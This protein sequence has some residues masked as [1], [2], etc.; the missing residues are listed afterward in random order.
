MPPITTD[1][2]PALPYEVTG[3]NGITDTESVVVV[4][5]YTTFDLSGWT[6]ADWISG[7]TDFDVVDIDGSGLAEA[8]NITG[9]IQNDIIKGGSLADVINGDD[10]NDTI[11]GGAG[12]DDIDGGAGIDYI[13]WG[14]SSNDLI[15]VLSDTPGAGYIEDTLTGETDTVDNVE[16]VDTGSGADQFTVSDS[17]DNIINAGAGIDTAKV[18]GGSGT[19]TITRDGD[20][21]DVSDTGGG[22]GTDQYNSVAQIDV[23][24]SGTDD[25]FVISDAGDNTLNGMGGADT[26]SY[27][28]LSTPILVTIVGEQATVT[29]TGI[30]TDTL[31]DID[32]IVTGSDGDTFD[33]SGAVAYHLDS[34]AGADIFDFNGSV[35]GALTLETSD[36]AT[37]DFA[38]FSG[39]GI[40]I[41]LGLATA[42]TIATGLDVTLAGNFTS[43]V[44]TAG[45]DDITGTSA[46]DILYGGDEADILNG[47]DGGDTLY[48]GGGNDD[49]DGGDGVDLIDLSTSTNKLIV[50]LSDT[51]GDGSIEDTVSGEIDAVDNVENVETGS[52]DDLFIV[53]DSDDNVL[54]G[55]G[56]TDTADYSSQTTPITVTIVA[57]QAT[58]AATGLGSDTLNDFEVILTGLGD[59]YFDISG[60]V[61]YHLKSGAGADTFYFNGAVDGTLVFETSD[62]AILDFGDFTGSGITIDLGSTVAQGIASGLSLQ[63]LSGAFAGIDGTALDDTMTG[64]SGADRLSGGAGAD[65][66][67]GGGGDDILVVDGADAVA[68]ETYDGGNTGETVGDTLKVS[69]SADFTG[70]TIVSIEKLAMGSSATFT[71][72]QLGAGLSSTLEVTGTNGNTD[73]VTIDVV[74][75]ALTVDLSGWTFVDW[76]PVADSDLIV[77]DGSAIVDDT[78][79]QVLTGTSQND[80]ITGGAGEDTIVGG[81][82]DDTLTGGGSADT[83][84][85]GLGI[86]TVYGGAGDDILVVDGADAVAGETYDGGADTD[87]LSISGTADFTGSTITSIEKLA[88]GSSA[89]FTSDQLGAGLSSTLEV[90]GTN[91]NT[92]TVTV[93]VLAAATGG[94]LTVDLSG[95]TFVDWLPVADSDLI[96]IDGS[97]VVD[98]TKDQVLTGTSQN[99]TITGGAGED[100]IVGGAGDDTLTGGGSAD[101]LTGGLG[102]D[103]VYGGAGDDILVVDGADAVAGETYDGGADTDT[104]SVSGTADFTGS[105]ITSIEKLAMGSSATFTSDQLGAGLS[106]TLEVTGTNGNTDTVTINVVD[107]ALTVDLSGWTFVDW[108]PVADSDLIVIDGSAIVD[109]TKD[110]VL[111]G[112]S[113]NDTI[114]GGA[115]ADTLTGGLGVDTVYGG[116][117]DDILVVDGADAVAGETYDGGA[118]TDTLSVSGTAD[119]TGSTITSIEKLAMGSSATFTSDQ[120]GAGLSSTLEVTGTNGNTDTV[121]VKVLAAATG[122]DLTVDL[123][124][125]TFVD[126]LPVAD[127]DLIVIDGSAVVD[128]TKNQ[129]LTGTSQNDTITGGAGDDTLTGLAGDDMLFGGAGNDTFVGFLGADTVDGGDDTDTIV[130]AATSTDLNAATNGRIINVEAVSAALAAAAVVIDLHLQSD[131]FLITGSANG[132]TITGSSGADTINA[133]AGNDTI[134]GFVGADTVNGGAD[135]DTI[136]LAATSTDL[137]AASNARIVNVEAISA[138]LAAAGVVIDLHLQ[139]DGFLVTGSASNDKIIGSSGIDTINAGSG[140]DSIEGGLG[141]DVINGEAG[142]D[143]IVGFVGADTVDGGADTDTIILAATSSDLNAASDARIVNVEAISAA[144]AAAPVVID[145]HLQSDGFLVTG[146]AWNDTITGS[147]GDDTINSGAGKDIITGRAGFDAI[148]AGANDDRIVAGIGDG[149]DLYNGGSGTDTVDYSLTSSGLKIDLT[150]EDRSSES[151]SGAPGSFGALL[152]AGGFGATTPV[153]YAEGADTGTDALIGIE[154]AIGSS[155]ADTILGSAV[156]NILEGSGGND[157]I[158]ARGG[159]DTVRGGTGNDILV[160]GFGGDSGQ[161]S[162]ND[163]LFGDEGNDELYGEDG[164]DE[165][166]GGAGSDQYAGGDGRD[167]LHFEGDGAK[168]KAWGGDA[169]D[170]FVFEKG[171]G[172]DTIKDFLATGS[173]SDK[174]DLTAFNGVS[175]GDLKIKQSG[176]DTTIGG[177]GPGN[178]IILDVVNSGALTKDDFIFAAAAI[179]GTSKNDKLSGGGKDDRIFGLGGKDKLKGK[180]GDDLLK[181]GGG[182]DKLIGGSGDDKLVGGGGP[183]TLKGG[184]GDDTLKGNAGADMLDGGAGL[185]TL[186]GGGGSDTFAFKSAFGGLDT[187]TDF[188]SGS[189]TIQVS[190]SGFGGGLVAGGA[191]PLVGLA[192]ITGYTHGGGAGVFLFDTSGADLGTI[193]WDANGGSSSDAIAFA[194]ISG[195]TLLQ[196]DFLIV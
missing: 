23:D 3:T 68:G 40:T 41:D 89:T 55:H 34:G 49:I 194:R 134:V 2:L 24:G 129:V 81:A 196:S 150:P 119:F 83:L 138:A 69:G 144:L 95:W 8:Q 85:G 98:D 12:N 172:K 116:A 33:I 9:T 107:T 7:A 54:S 53:T 63:L 43:I 72:D 121:T 42:Q 92:D 170:V 44:G 174:I 82:G 25:T 102:A 94:D 77:I 84:T 38:G 115:G 142:D 45:I 183:D 141:A 29:G 100:T 117:G 17:S 154:N 26:V 108:L 165:L 128:D 106:S 88:M 112:T 58:V 31:D 1:N 16:N 124:G 152:A 122:G 97:A 146:S 135:T 20:D 15:V 111:T 66:I 73:T 28:S 109:D 78:K 147:T 181:G 167:T 101:T 104:L 5:G 74:D 176:N 47:G 139:S 57:N 59:D 158:W 162:G 120:L 186:T 22:I 13:N 30:G 67:Y 39:S 130:L 182:G 103:T 32:K 190:A 160:G 46:A 62:G 151:V 79:D 51:P 99:D 159:N 180:G 36:G 137:N 153:G 110:Q 168:D 113:Q 96:V 148:D 132:D 114:T 155:G 76:L 169:R 188:V 193:Y 125:W 56:G 136:V 166:F 93:K 52:G 86:D 48:G 173:K 123:S 131:G 164:R 187:I 10:G 171:F 185:D 195:A 145:L 90:T 19:I 161:A 140:K 163:I 191:A 27:A 189:D 21:V 64:T 179:R 149:N 133:G 37:L 175:F 35:T 11:D 156:T 105:T 60:T 127:S 177:L 70:S 80:T 14:A 71:S 61:N 91:G 157:K 178:K 184:A 118:D 75:T 87:T 143:T 126:W 6:F 4:S 192:D 18:L 65:T 50:I